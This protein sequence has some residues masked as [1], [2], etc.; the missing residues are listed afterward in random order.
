MNK[1]AYYRLMARSRYKWDG[2]KMVEIYNDGLAD[3]VAPAVHQDT[4]DA[5]KSPI[6]GE[7]FESRSQYVR[8]V[9]RSGCNIVGNDLLSKAKRELKDTVTD[10]K[11]FNAMDKAESILRNPDK[12]SEY[13]GRNRELQELREKLLGR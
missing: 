3:S 1:Y 2:E 11:I 9:Q 4:M 13:I 5:L 6:T 12:M 7:I 8:H 10:E